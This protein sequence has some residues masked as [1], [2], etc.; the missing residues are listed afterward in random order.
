M[1]II[2]FSIVG[3]IK[4]N[5]LTQDRFRLS[6]FPVLLA[7]AGSEWFTRECIGSITTWENMVEK[8]IL[9]FH[10]LSDH[11]EEE[12]TK[13]DDNPNETDNV[14][15]IFKIEGNLFDFETPLCE[16]FYEFNYLLKTNTYLFINDIQNFK[17]YNEYERELNNDIAKGTDEPWSENGVPYQL[18][19]HICK[20]H[21]FKNGKT[22]WPTCTSDIDGFCNGGILPGMVRVGS[23]TYFQDHRW[24]DELAD[25]K[26]KDE[27]LALKAKIKGS[28]GDTTPGVIKFY[29]WLK[30]YFENFHELHYEVLVKLQECWW[31][32]NAHEIALFTRMENF[33][34]GPYANM[35]TKWTS[36][37]YLDVNRIFRR[38]YEACNFGDT[39]ENQG[40]EEHKGNPNL[41]PSNCKIR[42]FK[43]MK[44]SFDDD[45]EYITI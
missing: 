21:R 7:G 28:W 24:Y 2:L 5:G 25:G 38:D 10:H 44:Y 18:C 27:T 26:L 8:F 3:L 30:N 32:V 33:K 42:R 41:E 34:R 17:T 12:E 40:H 19:D 37:P 29:G 23:I 11:D 45:E 13:E 39:Q 1:A 14:P 9:K 6:V 4:I 20:P 16:A 31:K 22:K 36:N 43:M 15:E 35:K